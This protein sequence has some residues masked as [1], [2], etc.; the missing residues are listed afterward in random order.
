M[1][2]VGVVAWHVY[3]TS[4]LRQWSEIQDSSRE[5]R[6]EVVVNPITN[7]V[8]IRIRGQSQDDNMFA[9]LGNSL[10]KGLTPAPI[11]NALNVRARQSFDVY[12][13]LIPYCVAVD[14]LP[15][16][17]HEAG[18]PEAAKPGA[19][20]PVDLEDRRREELM[21]ELL[22]DREERQAKEREEVRLRE[23]KLAYMQGQVALENERVDKGSRFGREVV[24]VFG[25]LVNKGE[26]T[27]QKVKVRVYFLDSAGR[28]IGEE[29]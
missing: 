21:A 26:R 11:A 5:S 29:E 4:D 1:I 14:M 12:A 28:R 27:L 2:V 9:G 3:L 7:L 25:T 13:M 22:R 15:P 16:L 18:T 23:E 10:I 17:N 20:S 6:E 24:G 19:E 8:T